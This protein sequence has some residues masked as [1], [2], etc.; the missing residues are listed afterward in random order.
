MNFKKIALGLLVGTALGGAALADD[1]GSQGNAF[2][3]VLLISVDGLHALDLARYVEMHPGSAM[4]ELSAHGVTF[5][6]ARTPANSDSF[7]GFSRS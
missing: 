4:A 2:Q 1:F 3:H 6:N 5:T 7:P